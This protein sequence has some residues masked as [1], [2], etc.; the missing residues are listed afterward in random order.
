[1]VSAPEPGALH[2]ENKE[3]SGGSRASATAERG[4]LRFEQHALNMQQNGSTR[5]ISWRVEEMDT[6][7]LLLFWSGMAANLCSVMLFFTRRGTK[8]LLLV[9]WIGLVLGS[10][11]FVSCRTYYAQP[12]VSLNVPIR[13][14]LVMLPPLMI[15]SLFAGG[16]RMVH[17]TKTATQRQT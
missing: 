8:W 7:L 9:P 12:E 4:V 6:H 2:R 17:G 5:T 11:W 15:F 1:M 3:F 14:D 13:V 10:A 16:F